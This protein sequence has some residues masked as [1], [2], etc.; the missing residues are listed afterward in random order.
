MY[1]EPAESCN[2][3]T[4]SKTKIIIRCLSVLSSHLSIHLMPSS[5]SSLPTLTLIWTISTVRNP[6]SYIHS[7]IL[8]SNPPPHFI[9]AS[10]EPADASIVVILMLQYQ[11]QRN[12]TH[13]KCK[14]AGVGWRF[15]GQDTRDNQEK[16][17]S[18]T[19]HCGSVPRTICPWESNSICTT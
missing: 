7:R 10:P 16:G 17:T 19:Q 3:A 8:N 18:R 15:W 11:R 13:G 6:L 2:P 4:N 1:I 9:N 5:H 12:V 14:G